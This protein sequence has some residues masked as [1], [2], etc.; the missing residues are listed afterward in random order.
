MH[1]PGFYCEIYKMKKRH[2]NICIFATKLQNNQILFAF[3]SEFML[4]GILLTL[5][6]GDNAVSLE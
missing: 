5:Y 2:V 4:L 3:I 1:Y 6:M